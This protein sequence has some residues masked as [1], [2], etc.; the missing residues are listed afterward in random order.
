MLDI[1]ITE[2][3]MEATKANIHQALEKYRLY[4]LS[5]TDKDRK[6]IDNG[7]EVSEKKR[8]R[9]KYIKE[10]EDAIE[11]ALNVQEQRIIREG[12]IESKEHNWIVMSQKLGLK[13]TPYYNK[14]ARAFRRL[15]YALGI[16][17]EKSEMTEKMREKKGKQRNHTDIYYFVMKESIGHT[18]KYD[19]VYWLF[20][21]V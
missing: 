2:L 9:Y 20:Y 10:F 8:K 19:A 15:A 14:R 7:L 18:R 5:V 21:F 16:E 4:V 11:H 1:K 13:K 6:D 17:V 3:D 12:Y